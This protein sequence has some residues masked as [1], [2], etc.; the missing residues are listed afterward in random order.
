VGRAPHI[1]PLDEPHSNRPRTRHAPCSIA[2]SQT[3]TCRSIHLIKPQLAAQRS[4]SGAR[5]PAG[6]QRAEAL[7]TLIGQATTSPCS[8]TSDRI[9]SSPASC[10]R[11]SPFSANACGHNV[12]CG[13]R[14]LH[15]T[16]Q[17]AQ[18]WTEHRREPTAGAQPMGRS[19]DSRRG[20]RS[21]RWSSLGAQ[22][23]RRSTRCAIAQCVRLPSP[24]RRVDPRARTRCFCGCAVRA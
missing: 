14:Y 21:G 2:S 24:D 11:S 6:R 5:A 1:N 9:R 15:S 19:D 10:A 8:P 13:P 3:G 18:E 4:L 16:G 17:T 22:R 20:S 23:F 7:L 12:H